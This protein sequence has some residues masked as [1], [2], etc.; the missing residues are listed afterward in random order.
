MDSAPG[1]GLETLAQAE[2]RQ[3]K[4]SPVSR[5]NHFSPGIDLATDPGDRIAFAS[6]DSDCFVYSKARA[7]STASESCGQPVPLTEFL[8]W[9]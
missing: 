6:V 7:S 2:N 1:I 9:L 8:A 4:Q 5:D 3:N